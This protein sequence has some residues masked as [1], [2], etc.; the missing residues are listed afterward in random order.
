MADQ[1]VQTI[2]DFFH[3]LLLIVGHDQKEAT[4]YTQKI[5]QHIAAQSLAK[6]LAQAS[7]DKQADLFL[8]LKQQ[9]TPEELIPFL[10]QHWQP[11]QIQQAYAQATEDILDK[12]LSQIKSELTPEKEQ[13]ISSL[14]EELLTQQLSQA[15]L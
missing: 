2:E 15:N 10:K 12:Y 8:K 1:P 4:D 13:Q 7:Q 14:T 5:T 6:L 11:K 3:K 9:H